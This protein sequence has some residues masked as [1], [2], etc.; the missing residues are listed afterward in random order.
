[1]TQQRWNPHRTARAMLAFGFL[2]WCTGSALARPAPAVTQTVLADAEELACAPRRAAGGPLSPL[3][4]V[5]SQE[6]YL[7]NLLGP[8]DSIVIGAGTD[9]GLAVGQRYFV[10]RTFI[11]RYSDRTDSQAPLGLKTAGWIRIVATQRMAAVA[12]VVHACAGFQLGDHLDPFELPPLVPP[13]GP[14]SEAVYADPGTAMDSA[15]VLFGT[16]GASIIATTEFLVIDRGTNQ[17][18]RL[19][20][21]LTIFREGAGPT[22]PVTEIAEVAIVLLS[23]DWATTQILRMRD[24]VYAGDLVAVQ[25]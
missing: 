15:T 14:S 6:G 19:G 12:T 25:R 18:M 5:G 22:G 3:T 4:L 7:K 17:G 16:D 21:R 8:G 1:M 13:L 23:P 10:R 2:V 20:Q 24:V 11:P 9:Q